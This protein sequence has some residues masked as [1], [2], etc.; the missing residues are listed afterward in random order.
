[1]GRGFGVKKGWREGKL[2]RRRRT[3]VQPESA[4]R[5]GTEAREARAEA[6]VVRTCVGGMLCGWGLTFAGES[7][8]DLTGS[9]GKSRQSEV[10]QKGLTKSEG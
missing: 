10:R 6:E 9:C 7:D 1:M 3:P 5:R 2:E 4:M 8:G